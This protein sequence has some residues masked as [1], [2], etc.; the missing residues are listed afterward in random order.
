VMLRFL[1]RVTAAAWAAW[2]AWRFFGELTRGD[3][4]CWRIRIPTPYTARIG[5]FTITRG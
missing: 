4:W 5:K 1:C 2:L 3:P